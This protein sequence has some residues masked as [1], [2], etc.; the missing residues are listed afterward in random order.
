MVQD[1]RDR[2]EPLALASDLQYLLLQPV[3]EYGAT[4]GLCV[5]KAP[6]ISAGLWG[7]RPIGSHRECFNPADYKITILQCNPTNKMLP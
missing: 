2:P 1:K 6:C 4:A 7:E 3:W 5:V